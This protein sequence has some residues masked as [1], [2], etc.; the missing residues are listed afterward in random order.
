MQPD[1]FT[2]FMDFRSQPWLKSGLR[3]AEIISLQI[4]PQ[5]LCQLYRG[6]DCPGWGDFR[7]KWFLVS[8]MAVQ[9]KV[10]SLSSVGSIL[11]ALGA[12]FQRQSLITHLIVNIQCSSWIITWFRAHLCAYTMHCTWIPMLRKKFNNEAVG[13]K[14]NSKFNF[15]WYRGVQR[16]YT[17]HFIEFLDSIC[18]HSLTSS[19]VLFSNFG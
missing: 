16:K 13:G 6:N 15:S 9:R 12:D 10:V 7:L 11:N 17:L 3:Y 14:L 4:G 8:L 19:F 18:T 2:F 1:P 5:R